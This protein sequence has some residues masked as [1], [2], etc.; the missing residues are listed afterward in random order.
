MDQWESVFWSDVHIF[1]YASLQHESKTVPTSTCVACTVTE[2]LKA[3]WTMT[4]R[5]GPEGMLL[6]PNETGQHMFE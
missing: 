6:V 4:G 3:G 2:V 5:P 1:R